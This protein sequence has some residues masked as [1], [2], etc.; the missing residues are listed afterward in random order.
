MLQNMKKIVL[1]DKKVEAP[2]VNQCATEV[3][4][5]YK[6]TGWFCEKGP[7]DLSH[8]LLFGGQGWGQDVNLGH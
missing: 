8:A 2:A 5:N 7:V 4:R 6:E 1:F 3:Y